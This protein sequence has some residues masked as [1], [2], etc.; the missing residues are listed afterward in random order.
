MMLWYILNGFDR[1]KYEVAIASYARGVLME[2]V[3]ADV[4]S[5]HIPAQFGLWE[6]LS[7]RL[8]RNPIRAALKRI[9]ADFKADLW[10][11]N[12]IVLAD[13]AELALEL[14]VPFISHFHE[15]P[16]SFIYVNE[17][18][19]E[20]LIS[21]SA[22]VIGCSEV[23]CEGIRKAGGE[24]VSL[25]YSFID[26]RKVVADAAGSRR[27][28]ERLNVA[29]GDFM[30][31]MSGTTSERKGFDLFPE[32][33]EQL[34]DPAVHLVWLGSRLSNGYVYA[35]EQRFRRSGSRTRLHLIGEQSKDYFDYIQAADGFVLTS[36]QD[37]FPLVMIEAAMLG[38]PLVSFPSGGASE[39]I[40]PGNGYVT[41]DFNVAQMADR[42]RSVMRG[43]LQPNAEAIRNRA[44]QFN[45]EEGIRE[46][47]KIMDSVFGELK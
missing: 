3:P 45:V 29:P 43:E 38:K 5:Y 4:R 47:E 30:W 1:S 16:L 17:R 21:K 6:K 41:A 15:M 18:Q 12:T 7:F 25:L 11:L 2:E 8:G 32:I 42:M 13:A 10:Y 9:Q 28:R 31:I 40:L 35:V 14:K 33:A 23:T 36:R 37:P 24:K 46:W 39:F 20:T 19:F 34:D 26:H 27:V 44:M 22:R